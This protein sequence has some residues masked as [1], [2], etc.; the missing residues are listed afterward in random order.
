MPFKHL[1]TTSYTLKR[2][3]I[4][5]NNFEKYCYASNLYIHLL[6]IYSL[7]NHIPDIDYIL[8]EGDKTI[9]IARANQARQ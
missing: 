1:S 9:K 3:F 6:N 5:T 7:L 2:K 4:D 8:S